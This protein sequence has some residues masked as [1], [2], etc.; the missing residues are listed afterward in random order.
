MGPCWA[1]GLFQGR[2]RLGLKVADLGT[3][4]GECLDKAHFLE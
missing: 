1:L 3:F 2:R 4:L